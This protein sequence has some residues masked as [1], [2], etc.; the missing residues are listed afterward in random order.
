LS[1]KKEKAV[2]A[3]ACK[4]GSF[5]EKTSEIVKP[6]ETTKPH[7]NDA[8]SCSQGRRT[9]TVPKEPKFHSLHVPKSCITRKPT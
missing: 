3:S 8:S 4:P 1:R 5:V 2:L 6:K 9:L 7:K